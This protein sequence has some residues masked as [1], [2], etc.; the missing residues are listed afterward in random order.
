MFQFCFSYRTAEL[1]L[2]RLLQTYR[3]D[4]D[5]LFISTAEST[6]DLLYAPVLEASLRTVISLPLFGL[7]VA[8]ATVQMRTHYRNSNE[9]TGSSLELSTLML[10]Y[11]SD[12]CPVGLH[13]YAT[14][15]C[16]MLFKSWISIRPNILLQRLKQSWEK[17]NGNGG[18]EKWIR[19]LRKG[20]KGVVCLLN[21][22][23]RFL[24]CFF[25]TISSPLRQ[26]TTGMCIP[27]VD[28]CNSR[29]YRLHLS[30]HVKAPQPTPSHTALQV[31]WKRKTADSYQN[32]NVC[33]SRHQIYIFL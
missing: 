4:H 22:Q 10:P 6:G 8:L 29:G 5:Q 19:R 30:C 25:K 15:G 28:I 1:F 11:R 7:L 12:D 31:H 24:S 13:P 26:P 20:T 2:L 23:Q 17:T 27:V 9:R 14:T 3:V 21:H 32:T 33:A 16:K 18:W